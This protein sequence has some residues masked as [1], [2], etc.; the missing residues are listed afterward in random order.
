[1]FIHGPHEDFRVY[2]IGLPKNLFEHIIRISESKSWESFLDFF[3][4]PFRST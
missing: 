2:R 4:L 3:F 1:V